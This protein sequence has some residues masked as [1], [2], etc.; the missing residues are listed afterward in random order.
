MLFYFAE[1]IG[2]NLSVMRVQSLCKRLAYTSSHPGLNVAEAKDATPHDGIPRQ[3][4]ACSRKT[5]DDDLAVEAAWSS[6]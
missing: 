4:I 3:W 2:V 5:Q 1:P 6:G